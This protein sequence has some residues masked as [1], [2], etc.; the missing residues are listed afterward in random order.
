MRRIRSEPKGLAIGR[1]GCVFVAFHS[2][3]PD[4]PDS[5]LMLNPQGQYQARWSLHAK[6]CGGIVV[7]GSRVL[8]R[9][10]VV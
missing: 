5:V 2:Q 4:E 7:R 8:D 9:K 3:W 10:S 6:N 1:D